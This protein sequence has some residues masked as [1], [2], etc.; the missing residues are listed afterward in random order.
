MQRD[1]IKLRES[2]LALEQVKKE[3]NLH[4]SLTASTF[5]KQR[6]ESQTFIGRYR[7]GPDDDFDVVEPE[8]L[9]FNGTKGS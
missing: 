5:A 1:T 4:K 7:A 2:T 9:E 6:Q 3:V 8:D